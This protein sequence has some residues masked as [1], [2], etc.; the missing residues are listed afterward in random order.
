MAKIVVV[1]HTFFNTFHLLLIASSGTTFWA[2][3]PE[4]VQSQAPH[5]L[6]G[7]RLARGSWEEADSDSEGEEHR[8]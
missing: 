2:N 5:T 8:A 7:V 3:N 4:V 6:T 1:L